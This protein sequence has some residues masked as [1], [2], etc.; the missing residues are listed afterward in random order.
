MT[1]VDWRVRPAT[2]ADR[3]FLAELAPR[4]AFGIAPWR[5]QAIMAETMGAYL[6]HDLE[7]MGADGRVLVAEAPDATRVGAAAIG[8]N[9][10]F[11]GEDQ[12]YLGELAVTAAAEGHGAASAL[13]AAAEDWAREQGLPLVVLDTGAANARARAFYARHG[14]AE[15]SVRLT[16]VLT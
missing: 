6:Q 2:P 7:A 15:E 5:D 8:R 9:R 3:E 12:A 10:N 13:L 1:S 16:K 11:T 14:Y 4:L